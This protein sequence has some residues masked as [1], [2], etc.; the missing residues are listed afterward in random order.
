MYVLYH[1][2]EHMFERANEYVNNVKRSGFTHHKYEIEQNPAAIFDVS[3]EVVESWIHTEV[4]SKKIMFPYAEIL[5]PNTLRGMKNCV[6]TFL[7]TFSRAA[8]R[9][10]VDYE[11]ALCLSDFYINELEAC[12]NENEV[13]AVS[14]DLLRHYYLLANQKKK[15]KHSYHVSNAIVYIRQNIFNPLSV[16]EIAKNEGLEKHYFSAL[17]KNETGQS[18]S[19]F[20]LTEKL[21]Q[22]EEMLKDRKKSV[23][24]IAYTLCFCSAS[25]F[26]RAFREH[27]GMTPL[28]YRK[29]YY[30]QF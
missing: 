14:A 12:M 18:P 22:S 17:F 13:A 11:T 27:I 28:E 2:G 26:C 30:S 7:V 16:T 23:S 24:E 10:G 3:P 4:L 9:R 29:K 5:G 8:I 6:I 20:I 19:A 21:K 25:H 1:R 15:T